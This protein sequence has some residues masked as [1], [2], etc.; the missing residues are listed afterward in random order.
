MWIVG[1]VAQRLVQFSNH[2]IQ[3][4][5]EVNECIGGPQFLLQFFASNDPPGIRRKFDKHQEWLFLKLDPHTV[6]AQFPFALGKLE[7]SGVKTAS[8][9][10]EPSVSMGV[11]CVSSTIPGLS[12]ASM[13]C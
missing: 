1:V 12:I 8:G 7:W 2:A 9:C 6:L 4:D 11:D 5:V 3:T 10:A 13:E